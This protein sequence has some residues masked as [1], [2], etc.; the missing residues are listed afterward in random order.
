MTETINLEFKATGADETARKAQKV[1]FIMKTLGSS[2]SRHYN[3]MPEVL[4]KQFKQI[5]PEAKKFDHVINVT[6]DTLDKTINK[7]GRFQGEWLSVMFA[8]MAVTRVT[9][10]MLRGI[11][12]SFNKVEE[13]S[14]ALGGAVTGLRASFEFLKF[15]IF[16]SLNTDFWV[17]V[18][19]NAIKFTNWVSGLIN[20]FPILGQ[21]ILVA[22]GVFAIGGTIFIALSQY[23]LLVHSLFN[24]ATG[25]FVKGVGGATAV[26]YN[27]IKDFVTKSVTKLKDIILPGG[28]SGDGNSALVPNKGKP[29]GGSKTPTFLGKFGRGAIGL[30]SAAAGSYATAKILE[31]IG[32]TLADQEG[33][34]GE[35]DRVLGFDQIY[36]NYF[37]S[38][39]KGQGS[40]MPDIFKSQIQPITDVKD[41]LNDGLTPAN[42]AYNKTLLETTDNA[43][44]LR[45]ALP[46]VDESLVLNRS[47]VEKNTV[48]YQDATQALRD[49][50]QA[51]QAIR[52][53][54]DGSVGL[55]TITSVG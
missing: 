7:A 24:P 35:S 38:I 23:A 17:G 47:E 8:A 1:A 39:E 10:G 37:N 31:R 50:Q 18:I 52:D 9:T 41:L 36:G 46:Q 43:F 48:A 45:D 40:T 19:E 34:I 11:F 28:S 55:E 14:T 42:T 12:N 26:A 4:F 29:T 22:L 49:Y 51:L 30:A 15:S 32:D 53:L 21:T 6:N 27:F 16:N 5:T 44:S 25:L 13:N 20:N 3:T 2:I 33:V 54:Q